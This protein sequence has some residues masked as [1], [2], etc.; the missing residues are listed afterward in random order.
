MT[1]TAGRHFGVLVAYLLP[2][3]L[4]LFGL[5]PLSPVVLSW[6]MPMES[7]SASVGPPVY[8]LLAALALGMAVSCFRWLIVD[9]IHHRSG[10]TPPRWNDANLDARLE[11]FN[12]LVENHY[13]YYQFYANSLI[14]LVGTYFIHRFLRTSPLLGLGTDFGAVL[15]SMVLF[16]GS[17]DA[18][19]KYYGRTALLV[20]Q[21]AKKGQGIEMT[22]GNHHAEEGGTHTTPSKPKVETQSKNNVKPSPTKKEKDVAKAK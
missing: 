6:L 16:A 17:R 3:F 14:A 10:I 2:G 15:I 12:Y 20:G 21:V 8:A 11:A 18:L 5:A 19:A 9:A 22:N 13:R 7:F 4:C 1:D